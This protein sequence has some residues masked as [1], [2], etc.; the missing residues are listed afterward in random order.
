MKAIAH[1][2][3]GGEKICT[4]WQEAVIKNIERR[5]GVLKV[6]F[7]CLIVENRLW[8]MDHIVNQSQVYIILHNMIIEMGKKGGIL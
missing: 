5:F 7:W 2:R 8:F 4:K 6:R 3:D 1:P